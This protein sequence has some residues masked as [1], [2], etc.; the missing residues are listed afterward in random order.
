MNGPAGMVMSG[1][2]KSASPPP[3]PAKAGDTAAKNKNKTV[4]GKFIIF[5][6]K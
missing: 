6:M 4:A 3:P 5:D 2:R 1:G